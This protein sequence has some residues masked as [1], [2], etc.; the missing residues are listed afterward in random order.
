MKLIGLIL[1]LACI[2]DFIIAG[3]FLYKSTSFK[4]N[5][6]ET[7]AIVES[8]QTY[9]TDER[10]KYYPVFLYT[11]HEGR[12]HSICSSTGSYPSKY[13][14]LDEVEILY[15]P[16]AVEKIKV[17]SFADF[18]MIPLVLAIAGAI[19][20]V[21]SIAFALIGPIFLK[22]KTPKEDGKEKEATE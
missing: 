7:T 8:I 14:I 17:Y 16:N 10:V 1:L 13:E 5:A 15:N 11:D 22:K 2:I 18:Y 20:F 21:M 12:K 6:I 9:S 19:N 4:K 3:I